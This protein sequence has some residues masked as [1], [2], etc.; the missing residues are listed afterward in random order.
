MQAA[1]QP[2]LPISRAAIEPGQASGTVASGMTL[3]LTF[4]GT[5]SDVTTRPFYLRRGLVRFKGIYQGEDSLSARLQNETGSNV[6]PYVI[7]HRT[8]SDSLEWSISYDGVYR[9]KVIQGDGAWTLKVQTW[10]AY[11]VDLI[12]QKVGT[13]ADCD[14]LGGKVVVGQVD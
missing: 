7:V 4:T 13:A 2:F 1:A 8:S 5:G 14:G 9:L 3:P 10:R 6:G 12:L 11:C